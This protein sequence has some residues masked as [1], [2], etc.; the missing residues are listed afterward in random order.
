MKTKPSRK[1]NV[2]WL[3]MN[4]EKEKKMQLGYLIEI[5]KM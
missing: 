4:R 1:I 5:T 2:V 3:K